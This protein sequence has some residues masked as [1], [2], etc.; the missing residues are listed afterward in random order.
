MWKC[1][2]CGSEVLKKYV[3]VEEWRVDKNLDTFETESVNE[4]HYDPP[5]FVCSNEDCK[6]ESSY[7]ERIAEWEE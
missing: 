7:I 3:Q 4:Y 5:T 2:K 1:N 6:N